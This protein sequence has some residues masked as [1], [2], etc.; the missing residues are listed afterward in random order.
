MYRFT[1]ICLL[2]LGLPTGVGAVENAGIVDGIW[3]SNPLP[4][5]NRPTRIYVAIHN[6]TD[7][8]LEGTVHFRV[9]DQL[10]DTMRINALSGRIIESWADWVPIAGTST[11]TVDLRRTELASTASGTQT[12]A[13]VQPLTERSVYIDTDT[14]GDSIG[15]RIDED[16]DNDGVSDV[17]ERTAG[18][19]PLVYN[20][21][22]KPETTEP[23][24]TPTTTDPTTEASTPADDSRPGLE[25]IVTDERPRQLLRY[26]SD[27]ITRSKERLDAYR[28]EQ[29]HASATS[30]PTIVETT[31]GTI[32]S[33]T[34]SERT[35]AS[36]VYTAL[37]A[38][39]SWLL[40]YPALIQLLLLVAILYSL[41]RIARYYGRRARM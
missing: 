13:V 15:N 18:T 22:P 16:D 14:D 25:T 39:A 23:T 7:G 31:V 6:T 11:I 30:T 38:I 26:T 5:E 40:G 29:D 34:T 27:L 3:L 12:V 9:N 36:G 2:L 8:D 10:L 37:L 28:R 17:D 24:T 41:Y 1:V 35:G 21:P 32:T 19:D 4:V 20:L 33:A